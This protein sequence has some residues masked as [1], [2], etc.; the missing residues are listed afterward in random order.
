MHTYCQGQLVCWISCSWTAVSKTGRST[1]N[2]WTGVMWSIVISILR[3]TGWRNQLPEHV[4]F[5]WCSTCNKSPYFV[6]FPRYSEIM[7]LKN[8]TLPIGIWRP[9]RKWLGWNF[10]EILVWVNRLPCSI[11]CLEWYQH[12]SLY[13]YVAEQWIYQRNDWIAIIVLCLAVLCCRA[14]KIRTYIKSACIIGDRV[15]FLYNVPVLLM[16]PGGLD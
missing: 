8:F 5:Y 14:I 6:S 10:D 7:V 9:R 2:L 16:R 4:T 15:T 13:Q 12:V 11:G 3:A 1:E